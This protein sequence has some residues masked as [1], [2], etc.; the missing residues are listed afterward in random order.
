M[1]FHVTDAFLWFFLCRLKRP[2]LIFLFHFTKRC[3]SISI[4]LS[5]FL[6]LSLSLSLQKFPSY[7]KSIDVFILVLRYFTTKSMVI[8]QMFI[9][10]KNTTL[11][12]KRF[13]MYTLNYIINDL[14]N[15]YAK[16]L[17]KYNICNHNVSLLIL[18]KHSYL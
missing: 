18:L 7:G 2:S 9:Y 8:V 15:N 11:T 6:S 10:L 14:T 16:R 13:S 17:L 4:S 3:I 5:H 1:H 12:F